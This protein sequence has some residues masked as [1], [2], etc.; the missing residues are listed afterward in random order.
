[1]GF[2]TFAVSQLAQYSGRD[3]DEYP[4]YADW[5]LVEASLVFMLLTH[6]RDWPTDSFDQQLAQTGILAYADVLVLTQP[7]QDAKNNPFQSMNA[8]SV[9]WS[10][11]VAY[12]R[13]NAQSNALRGEQTGITMFDYA[14]QYLA[15][16]D[17]MGGVYTGSVHVSWED[18]SVWFHRNPYT[19]GSPRALPRRSWGWSWSRT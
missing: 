10:K 5:A 13:G 2:P 3:L 14:V 17:E 4:P 8:G 12:I 6:L 9:S 19:D 15:L 11:P 1:M 7:Y 18:D 16:R